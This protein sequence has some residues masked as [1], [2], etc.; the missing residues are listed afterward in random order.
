LGITFF[1]SM[2]TVVQLL[3]QPWVAEQP[4]V[5]LHRWKSP[6]RLWQPLVQAAR[7][8]V[9]QADLVVVA[10]PWLLEQRLPNRRVRS[11]LQLLAQLA[12]VAVAQPALP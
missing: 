11:R 10:Q 9:V 5:P 6:P 4:R 2:M 3:A 7:T 1:F 12:L 8:V